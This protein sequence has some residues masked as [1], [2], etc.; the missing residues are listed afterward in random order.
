MTKTT[1]SNESADRHNDAQGEDKNAL[2]VVATSFDNGR[3]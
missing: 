2:T 3:E 1:T